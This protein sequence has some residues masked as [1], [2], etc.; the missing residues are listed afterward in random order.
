MSESSGEPPK[1]ETT[2]TTPKS[3]KVPTIHKKEFI[4]R[5]IVLERFVFGLS[6]IVL[7]YFMFIFLYLVLQVCCRLPLLQRDT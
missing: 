6:F 5:A 1:E 2:T 4:K 3:P 7:D